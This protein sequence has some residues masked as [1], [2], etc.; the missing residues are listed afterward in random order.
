M[1]T[2]GWKLGLA[3]ALMVAA[4]V[5]ASAQEKLLL[6]SMSP[7]GS[8]NTVFFNSWLKKVNAASGGTIEIDMRDGTALANFGNVYDRVVNNVVQIGWAIHQVVAG[9]FPLTD[10]GGLPYITPNG[11]TGAVA[12]LRLYRQG[13]LD[14]E[15][16]EVV[17]LLMAP[18][19]AGHVHY[20]KPPH[21]TEDLRGVKVTVSGRTQGQLVET[22]GGAPISIPPQ[23]MY[24]ALHR[25]TVD[26]VLTSWAAFAPYKL[27]EVTTFHIEAP[28]GQNTSM[29][30]M[31]RKRFDALP[32]AARKAIAD[33]TGEA[34][35]RAFGTHFDRQADSMR[36]PAMA[37]DKHKVV[38]LSA[39]QTAAWEAKFAPVLAEWVK[40]RAGGDKVLASYRALIA[41]LKSN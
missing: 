14:N 20:A 11:A 18:F 17:P 32:E 9:K 29:F 6:T 10:V 30:F 2:F 24:E 3:A 39:A 28:L 12:L 19:P 25:A 16:K 23:D 21:S 41:Q 33:N 22:L 1:Q 5:P 13:V 15:Y 8:A 7:A 34:D 31:A 27:L 37:S 38:Q 40:A 35:A 4:A 26:A 36:T